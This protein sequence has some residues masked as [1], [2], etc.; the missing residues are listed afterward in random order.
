MELLLLPIGIAC[1]VAS[2]AHGYLGQTRLI[3]PAEFPR[4]W[5]RGFVSM[6]WQYSTVTWATIGIFIAS[7]P[8]LLS[9]ADR[10]WAVPASCVPI[11]Y[12]VI[13][14][15]IVSKGQHFGWKLFAAIIGAA[16]L[17]SQL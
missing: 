16:C 3:D 15:A 14:N 5:A 8:W 4:G 1:V 12:G 11:A 10:V 9:D 6:I 17:V 7:A 2:V 13:G